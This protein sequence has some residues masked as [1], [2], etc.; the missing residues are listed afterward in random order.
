MR[1]TAWIC[2][3]LLFTSP[4]MGAEELPVLLEADFVDANLQ[5]W[6]MSDAEAW[7]VTETDTGKAIEL[8]KQSK[9]KPEVRS[10]VNYALWDLREV[11]DFQLDVKL[12]STTRDYGHRDLCLFFGYQDPKHFYYVH[13]AKEADPHAH[14]VF[15][16]DGKP[17]VSIATDRTDGVS[18]TKGWHHARIVRDATSG[19]ITV[20]FDDMTKP[21]ISAKDTTF[22]WGKVGIGSF[23]DTG[24]FT[25]IVLRG[26]LKE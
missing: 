23:D 12:K 4:L 5:S 7:R 18:W 14:S 22:T 11:T 9:Y 17:R 10:P 24:M 15:L 19:T 21:I 25:D 1:T 3:W 6:K 16:V 13:M 20:Y 2:L 8:F 26:K